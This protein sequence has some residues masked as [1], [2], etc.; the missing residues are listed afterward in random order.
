MR[1]G[2]EEQPVVSIANVNAVTFLA[3][4]INSIAFRNSRINLP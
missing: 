4:H 1:I 2:E 3:V